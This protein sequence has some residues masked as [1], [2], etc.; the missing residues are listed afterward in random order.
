M[1]IC[2]PGTVSDAQLCTHRQAEIHLFS[3]ELPPHLHSEVPLMTLQETAV[4]SRGISTEI[5]QILRFFPS[6]IQF[7]SNGCM[8]SR[9]FWTLKPLDRHQCVLTTVNPTVYA[10]LKRKSGSR[11]TCEFLFSFSGSSRGNHS[12]L[13]EGNSAEIPQRKV[14]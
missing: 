3:P 14:S 9:Y 5:Q 1:G 4:S 12:S 2:L 7:G 6:Q 13:K 10:S 8:S 11:G